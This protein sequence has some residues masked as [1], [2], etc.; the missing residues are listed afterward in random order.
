MDHRFTSFATLTRD[1]RVE[2][3]L[4]WIEDEL[5]LDLLGELEL[6]AEAVAKNDALGSPL[7]IDGDPPP[8]LTPPENEE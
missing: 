7:T 5:Q 8:T 6:A 1:E 3:R 2:A 4:K